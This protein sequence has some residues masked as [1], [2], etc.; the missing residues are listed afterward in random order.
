V[1]SDKALDCLARVADL[2]ARGRTPIK[3]DY[4]KKL[5]DSLVEPEG[6]AR[7]A[8]AFRR[9]AESLALVRGH[10]EVTPDDLKTIRR[11]AEDTVPKP[12]AAVYRVLYRGAKSVQELVKL[13]GISNSAIN[14]TLEELEM[15][16][17]VQQ[18]SETTGKPGRPA[19]I[20]SLR[21]DK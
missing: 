20:W 19:G 8:K 5:I 11:V 3:R 18:E 6:P 12:R 17:L 13:T 16:E 4:E 15:L 1:I 14:R 9:L 10:H 2:V 21:I 7:L